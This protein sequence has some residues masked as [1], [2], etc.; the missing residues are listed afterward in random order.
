LAGAAATKAPMSAAAPAL[1]N[2]FTRSL[3]EKNRLTA[4]KAKRV[5]RSNFIIFQI[6]K[7]APPVALQRNVKITDSV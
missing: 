6:V 2:V 3:L 5:P 4:G 1:M 7:S